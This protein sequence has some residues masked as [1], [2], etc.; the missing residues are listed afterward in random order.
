[1]LMHDPEFVRI[2]AEIVEFLSGSK[3]AAE[4]SF[5]EVAA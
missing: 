2:Q 3:K 1:M 4:K 5:Q